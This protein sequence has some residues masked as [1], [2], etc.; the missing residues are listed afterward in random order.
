[1][2]NL[3]EKI[4]KQPEDKR[5]VIAL[6]IT[7]FITGTIFI[8]WLSVMVPQK[9][10]EESVVKNTEGKTKEVQGPSPISTLKQ[11]VA[12]AYD[13]IKDTVK[14]IRESGESREGVSTTT[15]NST[16]TEDSITTSGSTTTEG[17][18]TAENSTTTENGIPAENSTTTKNITT[19]ESSTT[20]KNS[21][22]TEK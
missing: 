15:G 21:T 4:R 9:F 3:L 17:I 7:I 18:T 1:M 11:S 19:G 8:V 10:E 14:D 12:R 2:R 13:D 20:R 16:T 22:T 5:K 6:G